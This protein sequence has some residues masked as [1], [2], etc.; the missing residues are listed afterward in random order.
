VEQT[1]ALL[2][3]WVAKALTNRWVDALLPHF[4]V[5]GGTMWYRYRVEGTSGRELLHVSKEL[6]ASSLGVFVGALLFVF[7]TAG[8]ALSKKAP[9]PP[10]VVA[11]LL[12]APILFVVFTSL[13]LVCVQVV[14]VTQHQSFGVRIALHQFLGVALL[15][16]ASV[17][18]LTID[19]LIRGV[20]G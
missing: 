19:A 3:F 1:F 16:L 2:I 10:A 17:T 13:F 5:V 8:L 6:L 4:A 14:R 18:F 7:V 9:V 20:S 11:L 15:Y 12:T